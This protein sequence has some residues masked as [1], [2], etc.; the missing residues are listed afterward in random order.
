MK[1]NL[2]GYMILKFFIFLFLSF[3]TINRSHASEIVGKSVK[4][5]ATK[6]PTRGYPFFFYFDKKNKFYSFY[7]SDKKVKFHNFDYKQ[8]NLNIFDLS[9]IGFFNKSDLIL[10]HSKYNT[11]CVC[12]FLNSK[13]EIN[14]QLQKYIDNEKK[15]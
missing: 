5:D 12:N 13:K 14:L 11:K 15:K 1:L 2:I 6:F 9:R 10:T 7:I 4:C 8:I 3:L